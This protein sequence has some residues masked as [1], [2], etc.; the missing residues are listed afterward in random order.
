M[1]TWT[2]EWVNGWPKVTKNGEPFH[3]L[4]DER[5]WRMIQNSTSGTATM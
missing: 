4:Y 5:L 3:G 1:D 2:W